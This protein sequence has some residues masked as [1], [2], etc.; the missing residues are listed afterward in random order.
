MLNNYFKNTASLMVNGRPVTGQ[1]AG[2]KQP[3]S[4]PVWIERGATT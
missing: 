2:D 3:F 4:I 1:S